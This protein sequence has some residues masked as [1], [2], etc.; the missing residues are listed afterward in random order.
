MFPSH[1]P[2]IFNK[3]K[4]VI[5]NTKPVQLL[6]IGLRKGTE[7]LV[8]LTTSPQ[9]QALN[10]SNKNAL[11]AAGYK[12][13]GELGGSTDP[14]RIAGNPADNVFAG[15]NAQSARGNI[16]TASKNRI[17][18]IRASAAKTTDKAKAARLNAK[19]DKFEKQRQQVLDKK[20][21]EQAKINK[22]TM[23]QGPPRS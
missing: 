19:A 14:G 4:D 18:K 3:A 2:N 9:Q 6:G 10:R 11:S 5:S 1:D 21:E 13:R 12:T 8:N 16:M 7:A 15:M 17:D 22:A 23:N 20:E